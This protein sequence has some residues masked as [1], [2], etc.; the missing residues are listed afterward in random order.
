VQ[1]IQP[2]HFELVEKMP[3]FNVIVNGERKRF[4]LDSGAPYMVLNSRYEDDNGTS[5]PPNLGNGGMA[6]IRAKPVSSFEWG[7]LQLSN[8]LAMV[9]ELSHLEQRLN[10]PVHGLIGC[11]QFMNYDLLLDYRERHAAL[12]DSYSEP[13]DCM[14]N[15]KVI[16]IL[17]S[18]HIP[19][20]SVKIGEKMFSF[21]LDT[22]ASQNAIGKEHKGYL[23]EKDLLFDLTQDDV[24]RFNIENTEQ[25]ACLCSVRDVVIGDSL[26]IDGMR[27]VFHDI[28]IPG[29][30][31]D[32]LLGYELFN[33][34][35]VFIRYIKRELLLQSFDS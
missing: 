32:G 14:G 17:M 34:Q 2:I 25:G 16:P 22:G 11:A 5:T 15:A 27:F 30:K 28:G 29:V 21:G 35:K 8:Q 24:V 12:I 26:T 4:I 33:R 20:L 31:A 1:N 19:V 23:E 6:G 3:M 13:P 7:P 10:T 9:S 18:N